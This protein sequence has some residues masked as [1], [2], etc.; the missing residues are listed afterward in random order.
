MSQYFD[1]AV[2]GGGVIGCSVAFHLAQKGAKVAV[3]EKR[4]LGGQASIVAAG[5]LAAQEEAAGPDAF[6][7]VCL[8]S[9]AQFDALVPEV[10]AL[11]SVDPE[12]ET[13]GIWRVAADE[14]EIPGLLAKKKWQEARGLSV[15]WV[16]PEELKE[17]HPGLAPAPGALYCP[18]DGQIN[19]AR[20][21]QAL[22]EAGR[23]LGVRFLDH[24]ES[25]QFVREG[26][27]ISGI[28][29]SADLIAADQV[30]VAA[31]AW[32]PFLLETLGVSLPLEPVK[33]QLM[34]LNGVPRAFRG[35]VYAT[36]GYVVPRADGR[37]I[38]GA[39]A[40]RVGFNVRP[41]L[42]AQRFLADWVA[43]WCPALGPMPVMEFQ[44]GLRPGTPDGWPVVGRLWEFDN[45]YIAAGH[46]RNGI[47]LSPWT[48]RYMA[49]GLLDGRWDPRGDAFSPE[50]FRRA[51]EP[52]R[53]A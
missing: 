26:R 31:G 22:E 20:W 19:S 51:S 29:A 42:A 52:A 25:V 37:L 53:P 49:E 47:L 17:I 50:R 24:A 16:S 13:A 23:R 14:D 3:V 15:H 6:F 38:I 48:G 5:M 21:V 43:R 4:T 41:T 46:F 45:L 34:V 44:A 11:S 1:V 30:V 12:W 39:T 40:E 9:R 35:P 2:A 33:G 18:T 32:T 8:A 36:P 7:D 10:R 27:R 28:R